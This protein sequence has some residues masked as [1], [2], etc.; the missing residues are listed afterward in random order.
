M[1]ET[2]RLTI[3]ND[4]SLQSSGDDPSMNNLIESTA[5]F[6]DMP[7]AYVSIIG[8]YTQ[9]FK[10]RYGIHFESTDRVE[11]FCN[12]V[13]E[14]DDIVLVENAEKDRLFSSNPMVIGSPFIRFYAGIPLRLQNVTIG[15][16]CVVD[17]KPRTLSS[18]QIQSL[19]KLSSH[20]STYLD[21]VRQQTQSAHE[22]QLIEQSPAVLMTWKNF[23]GLNLTFASTNL[24]QL[25][26]LSLEPLVQRQEIFEDYIDP[27]SLNEFTFLMSNHRAGV[28]NADAQFQIKN[29]HG[30]RFW[31]KMI[32]QAF[33]DQ[34]GELDSV[35]ALLIDNTMNRSVEQK[36]KQTNQQMRILLEASDL[37]TWDYDVVHDI[38]KVNQYSCRMIGV[39]MELFDSSRHYWRGLIHPADRSAVESAYTQHLE[40]DSE[41]LMIIYRV[42]HSDGHWI[43]FETYGKTIERD[44][45]GHVLRVA[46]IHRD[47]TEKKET[48]LLQDKQRQLLSFINK[49]MSIYLQHNDLSEACRQVLPELTEI[50][51]SKFAFIAQMKKKD[52]RDALYIHAITELSWN[53]ATRTLVDM[54]HNR[55]LY[56]TSF[57]NLFGSVITKERMVI[58]NQPSTHPSSKGTPKGHPKIFRFMG[59]PIKLGSQVVGMIG[60]ANKIDDYTTKDS[61]LLQPLTDALAA[62]YYSVDLEDA[63]FKAEQQLKNMAMTDPLTGL[64]NRRAFRDYFDKLTSTGEVYVIVI[65]DIDHFKQVNDQYGHIAG[66]E[67]LKSIAYQLS[68]ELRTDDIIAR[69]GGEEFAFLIKNDDQAVV[70]E[71]LNHIRLTI[72]DKVINYG[73][74]SIHITMSMGAHFITPAQNLTMEQHIDAA[75]H[76]LYSAKQQGR[77]RVIWANDPPMTKLK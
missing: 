51:D 62:L 39:D 33:F 55:A 24:T 41:S 49:A 47:I 42:K 28:Q 59:L 23:E 75:D 32:S 21:L 77:N 52:N 53:E 43:W 37:G 36:L 15:A 19:T 56:F 60:L 13:V 2:Q 70:T 72:A 58:S 27:N 5:H 61:Q 46:G 44:E 18:E 12:Q 76:A 4:Y 65:L 64:S 11:A 57:D 40:G 14:N 26:G 54:Y 10:A 66:D 9:V 35:H 17:T 31:I 45:E 16:V 63:R 73:Q 3:I 48:E 71:L 74:H 34:T 1:D 69:L 68:N 20:I 29:R 38:N 30:E 25:F 67:V 6:L 50:A 22:H 8:E 7:I